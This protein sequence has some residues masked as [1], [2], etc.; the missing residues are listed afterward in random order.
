[1]RCIVVIAIMLYSTM[2]GVVFAD[3]TVIGRWCDRMVPA[4]PKYNQTMT[5]RTNNDGD[6][7]LYSTFGDGSKTTA[8]LVEKPSGTFLKK[9]STHGDKYRI[10]QNNGDLRLFD[11]DGFIRSASRLGNNPVFD[12]CK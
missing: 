10:A 3:Q 2:S 9:G 11:N 5:I 7:E 12:E 1:M 4:M 6:L 8:M